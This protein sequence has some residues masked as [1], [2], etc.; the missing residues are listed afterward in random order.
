VHRGRLPDGSEVAVKV[1]HPGIEQA[2]R[3]DL[4]QAAIG[5]QV[6]RLMAPGANVAAVAAELEAR[7]LEECD[8]T[9]EAERQARFAAWFEHDPVIVVPRVLAEWCGPGV[10]VSEFVEGESWD[11]FLSRDPAQEERDVI[12]QA[13]YRFFIGTLYG[14]GVLAAD[15]HPGNFIFLPGRRVAVLDYGS[16]RQFEPATVARLRA[17]SEAVRTNDST[18]IRELLVE[19]GCRLSKTRPSDAAE[20]EN[21]ARGFLAPVIEPGVH[22]MRAGATLAARELLRNKR[23]ML[24]LNLPPADLLLLLRIRFG[25]YAVLEQ[26]NARCDWAALEAELAAPGALRAGRVAG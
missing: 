2:L 19:L 16:V 25:L 14:R 21:F 26:L 23:A 11:R 8:Y 18:R 10:L 17:L 22:V 13:L 3:A 9:L 12:G 20:A 15:P 7:L 4:A 6:A 1:R 5:R 24:R